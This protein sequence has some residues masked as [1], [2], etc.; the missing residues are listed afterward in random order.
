MFN[1]HNTVHPAPKQ[2]A[3][4]NLAVGAGPQIRVFTNPREGI[5]KACTDYEFVGTDSKTEGTVYKIWAH[6]LE[7]R[8]YGLLICRHDLL[9]WGNSLR[10]REYGL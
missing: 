5:A 9:N 8:G 4:L 6:G 7:V 2:V 1:K 3:W 10:I